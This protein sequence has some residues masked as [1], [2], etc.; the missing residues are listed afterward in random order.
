MRSLLLRGADALARSVTWKSGVFGKG[1]GQT[2]A[3]WAAESNNPLVL[4][5]L[6]QAE[7]RA[8]A[9]QVRTVWTCHA[10]HDAV[11]HGY[12]PPPPLLSRPLLPHRMSAA[13]R[14]EASRVLLVTNDW[15]DKSRV[16][17]KSV[18]WSWSSV[19]DDS[20]ATH[21]VHQDT[22]VYYVV[23][24][25]CMSSAPSPSR[26]VRHASLQPA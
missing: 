18:W 17:S 1:S 23:T 22:T 15:L 16:E 2:P 4:E 25:Q 19:T 12:F 21:D 10:R 14:P 24:V 26:N 5:L 6:A 20:E 7:P 3:H 8:V 13:S 11:A 9:L